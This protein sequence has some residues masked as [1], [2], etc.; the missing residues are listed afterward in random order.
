MKFGPDII[1]RYARPD[2]MT[3]FFD[4]LLARM[5]R[6]THRVQLVLI[7]DRPG[8]LAQHLTFQH[9]NPGRQQG[10]I[11]CSFNLI[12]RKTFIAGRI[13]CHQICDLLCKGGGMFI[14]AVA[15]FKI[16]K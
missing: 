6:T 8:M 11:A 10:G 13:C 14:C 3:H 16:E 9:I 4:R 15:G 5:Y 1:F 2:R 7:L 12:H